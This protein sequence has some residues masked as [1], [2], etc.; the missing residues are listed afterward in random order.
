MT[1]Y[2]SFDHLVL[3]VCSDRGKGWKFVIIDGLTVY[4]DDSGSNAE[5][6]VA[7]A[8]FCVSTVKNWQEL[9]KKWG[10]IASDAGFDLKDFHMTEFAACRC[11]S[12]CQQCKQGKTT[13]LD[14]PWQKW[15]ETKRKSVL[16]RMA[17]AMIKYVE[18]GVGHAVTKPDYDEHVRNSDARAV[19]IE[20]IG[21][22]YFTFA[23]QRC[24][25]SLAEWR[26]NQ[27]RMVP[28][29]FVFDLAS[30]R[31]KTEIASVFFSGI[32]GAPQYKNGVEQWL[33][34]DQGVS[35]ESRKTTHQLLAADIL[36]WTIATIRARQLKPVGRFVEVYWL[37][38]TFVPTKNIR[39]GYIPE[40]LA[41]WEKGKLDEAARKQ[42][43]TGESQIDETQN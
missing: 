2:S 39:I 14:H 43:G 32:E 6:K 34:P 4:V 7:A 37:A 17:K 10:K 9:L 11:D 15:S 26:A 16:T 19:A 12:L 29:K 36:A 40:S 20:P 21:D 42:Q 8:A 5:S 24:G 3:S 41:D 35:Y 25:D 33:T 31:E 13:S 1:A 23:V 38:K 18:F 22:E 28:L 27:S 30:K